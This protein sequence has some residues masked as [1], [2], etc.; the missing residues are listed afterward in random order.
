MGKGEIKRKVI[1]FTCTLI[2]VGIHHLPIDLSRKILISLLLVAIVVEVARRTV[3]F[4][5]DLFMRFFGGMLRDYEVRGITGATYLLLSAAFVTFLFSKNI[6]VLS[7]LFLTVGDASAT[8]FGRARGRKK[9][10]K[11]K[12]LEGTAAFFLTSL[13]VALAL[14]Y[15]PLQVR[16]AG[17]VVATLLEVFNTKIDDNLLLPVGSALGMIAAKKFYP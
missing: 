13:L 12:T 17:V 15:E 6:A 9:I 3:T 10:Y 16:I 2:P 1:H 8:V 11:D 4:F 14:R 7:L 5:R